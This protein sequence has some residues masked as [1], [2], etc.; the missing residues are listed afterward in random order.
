MDHHIFVRKAYIP[1]F[2]PLVPF[3]HVKKFM[4]VGGWWVLDFSVKPKIK[5][6][7]IQNLDFL[8]RW[9]ESGFSGFSQMFQLNKNKVVLK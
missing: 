5:T 3:L 1:N 4:V 6:S 9:G 2:I 8:I 7:K